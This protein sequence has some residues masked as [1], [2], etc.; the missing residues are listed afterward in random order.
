M[1][2]LFSRV[3]D[4]IAIAKGSHLT[5]I[6][7]DD[8]V[9]SLSAILLDEDYYGWIHSG[10]QVVQGVPIVGPVHLIPLKAKAW[11]DL[12][13]RQ[14]AGEKVKG[15]D[16]KKHKNDVFRLFQVIDPE[17]KARPPSS[18]ATDMN[19]FCERMKTEQVDLK[20]LGLASTSLDEILGRLGLIY[21]AD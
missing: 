10:T 4:A 17:I 16:I 1:L 5:P 9:S 19:S 11:L 7:I 13:A 12:R 20:A 18:I 3:P 6:P 21:A 14:E 2:E 8:E 15:D